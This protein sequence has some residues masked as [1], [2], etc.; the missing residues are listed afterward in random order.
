MSEEQTFIYKVLF[1]MLKILMYDS[2][3]LETSECEKGRIV[4]SMINMGF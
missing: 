2:S 1:K 4:L 3:L